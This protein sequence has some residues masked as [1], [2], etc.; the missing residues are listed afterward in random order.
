MTFPRSQLTL[1]WVLLFSICVEFAA[2]LIALYQNG[3]RAHI[4]SARGH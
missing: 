3:A 2:V 1:L 4:S